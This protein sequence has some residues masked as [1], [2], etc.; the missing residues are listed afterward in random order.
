MSVVI[1]NTLPS[2]R[3]TEKEIIMNNITT[4]KGHVIEGPSFLDNLVNDRRFAILWLPIRIWLGYK[5]LDA[6]LHKLDNPA[7][8]KTGEALK[9]YWM[10]QVAIPEAGR[11]AIAFDWYRSFLQSMLE[12]EVYTWFAKL[13]VYGELLVG[14]ALIIGLFTGIAAFFGA[15]MNW[16]FMMAGSASSN[17]LLF[18]AALGLIFAWKIAG[19]IGADYFLLPTLGT[20]WRTKT[21]PRQAIPAAAG[22]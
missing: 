5:W 15:F 13:V 22:D 19:H 21:H 18:V 3:I 12:A 10:N 11:P 16:N 4:R 6:A 14:V 8:V 9:G 2:G 17:P 7:W 1:E 20:P